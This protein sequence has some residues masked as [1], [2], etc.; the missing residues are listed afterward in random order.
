[1]KWGSSA[2]SW[3]AT[4]SAPTSPCTSACSTP[5]VCLRQQRRGA[6]R[7][8]GAEADFHGVAD[9]VVEVRPLERIAARKHHQGL[10]KRADLV[11]QAIALFSRQFLRVPLGLSRGPAM[12]A[13]QIASL[14]GFPDHQHRGL[15]EIHRFSSSYSQKQLICI[16]ET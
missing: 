12:Y 11:E 1:M 2:P 10:P 8:V 3:W 7:H 13:R 5:S 6:G 16:L 15:I 9:Q 14:G 4:A